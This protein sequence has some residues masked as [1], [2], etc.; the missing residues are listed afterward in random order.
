MRGP[1]GQGFLCALALGL[2]AA[3]APWAAPA[4]E[5]GWAPT[6]E[7]EPAAAPPDVVAPA[8][9]APSLPV[10]QLA[11]LDSWFDP[12]GSLE[13]RVAKT[14]RAALESGTWSFDPAARAALRGALGGDP[15][16]RAQAAVALAPALPL[17]HMELAEAQWLQA[18]EVMAAMRAV[19]G[20]LGAIRL[21]PEAS[22]WFLGSGLFVLAVAATGGTLLLLLLLALRCARHASHD[23]GHLAPGDPPPFAR[24]AVLAAL[25]LL[26]LAAGEGVL[27]LALALLFLGVVYGRGA[28]RVVLALAAA[29]LWAGLFPMARLAGAAL[30]GFPHDSVARAAYSL[31]GG[32]ASPADLARLEAAGEDPLALRALAIDARRRGH[33]GR[34]DALYQRILAEAAPDQAALN[35][36]ANVRLALGHME[37]ALDYYGRALD[38][39]E[40]PVVYFN[41]S[42][43]YGRGFQVDELNR[44]LADAQR[45]DGELVAELT[46][47]Q[48]ESSD[49]FFVVDL[50]LAPSLLWRRVL[51]PGEGAAFGAALRAP[52]APG[53]LGRSELLAGVALAA[54][55]VLGLAVGASLERS[56]GCARCASRMCVRCGSEGIGALCVSCDLLFNHPE[57]TDRALRFARMEALRRRDRLVGRLTA[58]ASLCVPGAAGVLV[59][60]PLRAF[61]GATAFAL[62]AALL[63][64]RGGVVPDPLVAGSAAQA[65]FGSVAGLAACVYLVSVAASLASRRGSEP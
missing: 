44:A 61:L 28:Q 40:S 58:L 49:R 18:D 16:E 35:N 17:A 59:D 46:A 63:W 30:E 32:L 39:S 33:L 53:R 38:L 10:P 21:H 8:P 24:F 48:R 27:G 29:A 25:L 47:L 7:A 45:V 4:Q 52:L 31:A 42:Q 56:R 60:R 51:A 62:A 54:A 34:A 1:L 43:A 6:G 26:P 3:L 50:P 41:L 57:R 13:T 2:A 19:Q 36:A 11:L 22:L 15:I 23:L 37:S 65:V 20:A 9:P 5:E 55:W 14:R 12:S 64:W